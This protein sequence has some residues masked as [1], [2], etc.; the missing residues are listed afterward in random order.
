MHFVQCRRADWTRTTNSVMYEVHSKAQDNNQSDELMYEMGHKHKTYKL[1]L[2][3][4]A[5]PTIYP[6]NPECGA[7]TSGANLWPESGSV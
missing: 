4:G 7:R 5:V 3:A 6:L 1:R 2:N